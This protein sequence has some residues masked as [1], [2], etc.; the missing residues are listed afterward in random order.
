MNPNVYLTYL[1]L[2][3]NNS[4]VKQAFDIWR[5]TPFALNGNWRFERELGSICLV[6]QMKYKRLFIFEA[7]QAWKE[8]NAKTFICFLEGLGFKK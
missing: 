2:T 8:I 1:C 6:Q 3:N 7:E 4:N 5:H